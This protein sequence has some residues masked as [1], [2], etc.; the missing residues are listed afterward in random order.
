V[1]E[2]TK[3]IL[4]AGLVDSTTAALLA[5]WGILKPE[6]LEQVQHKQVVQDTLTTFIEKLEELLDREPGDE[7]VDKPMRETFFEIQVREPPVLYFNHRQ[8]YFS[9][10][11][12]IMG[13]LFVTPSHD[14]RPG[15]LIFKDDVRGIDPLFKVVSVD[16][17]YQDDQVFILQLTV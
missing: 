8:G 6:E 9:A 1:K 10:V 2:L 14:F 7:T 12:D 15:D 3:K 11:R 5:R 4:E 16:K 17:L 13:R